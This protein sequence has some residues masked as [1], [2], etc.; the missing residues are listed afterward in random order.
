[1]TRI[2]TFHPTRV[3]LPT[4]AQFYSDWPNVGTDA[5]AVFDQTKEYPWQNLTWSVGEGQIIASTGLDMPTATAYEC[6][7]IWDGDGAGSNI[8]RV[9]NAGSPIP[10]PGVD[11]NL[12]YRWYVRWTQPDSVDSLNNQHPWQDGQAIGDCNWAI[13]V[14]DNNNGTWT[15]SIEID[16]GTFPNDRWGRGGGADIILQKHVTYRFELRVHRVSTTHFNMYWRIYNSAGSIVYD[17]NNIYNGDGAGGANMAA[18]VNLPFRNVANLAGFNFG[19]NG[20]SA[21]GQEAQ[22]PFVL[23]YGAAVEIRNDTWCGAYT[24]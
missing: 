1:M 16:V 23:Y 14:V 24:G 13:Q 8:I 18:A 19:Q 9:P 21:V 15:P 11:E 6:T 4:G 12:Y 3:I 7:M 10:V 5:A 17:E 20:F 22:F 2:I